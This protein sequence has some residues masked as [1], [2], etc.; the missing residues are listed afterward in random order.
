MNKTV[1]LLL[2]L[3][4]AISMFGHGIVRLPKLQLFSEWMIKSLEPS[5]IP[6]LLVV[7][8]SYLLP[9]LEFFVG[10]SLLLG[11]CTRIALITGAVVILF[12]L[13]G[14]SLIENW[15]AIP[16]QLIHLLFFTVLLQFLKSNTFS[17]DNLLS[18]NK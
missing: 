15:E 16:S 11:I 10:L 8:F 4:I 3:G 17:L 9:V 7:P 14:T 1:F 2:R 13:F 12:L 5:F 6:K 18:K